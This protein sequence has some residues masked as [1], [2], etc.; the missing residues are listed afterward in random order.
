MREHTVW[1]TVSKKVK[2][3]VAIVSNIYQTAKPKQTTI[4][5]CSTYP[6]SINLK[7]QP[8]I[9]RDVLVNNTVHTVGL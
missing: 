8:K 2:Y 9:C 7:N 4:E 1:L 5:M 3:Y 6:T